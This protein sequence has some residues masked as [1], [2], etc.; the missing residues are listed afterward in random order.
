ME[1]A[2]QFDRI[3]QLEDIN[4]VSTELAAGM[5]EFEKGENQS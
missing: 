2:G 5:P 3:D 1:V 4:L